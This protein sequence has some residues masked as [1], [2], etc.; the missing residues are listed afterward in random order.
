MQEALVLLYAFLYE[1][2]APALSWLESSGVLGL[3]GTA[4]GLLSAP[5]LFGM[6]GLS[7]E[8]VQRF[9]EVIPCVQGGGLISG[10]SIHFIKILQQTVIYQQYKMC[11]K[12]KWYT[13]FRMV[14][15][16]ANI[17]YTYQLKTVVHRTPADFVVIFIYT[18]H[19]LNNLPL[20]NTQSSICREKGLDRGNASFSCVL[21]CISLRYPQPP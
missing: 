19:L 13:C 14:L 2:G 3:A 9:H 18:P 17:K 21:V 5:L 6:L 11:F 12:Y 4:P 16:L 10:F 15:S 7:Y 8:I 1:T 20:S